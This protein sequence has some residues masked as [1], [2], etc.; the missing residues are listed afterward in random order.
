MLAAKDSEEA[1]LANTDAAT[2][3]AL[4][5]KECAIWVEATRFHGSDYAAT[6]ESST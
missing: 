6:L 3:R 5:I 2:G 1:A 4:L